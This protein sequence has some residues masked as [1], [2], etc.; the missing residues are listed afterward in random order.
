MSNVAGK[1]NQLSEKG[2]K[3]KTKS[4][5]KKET[6]DGSEQ[7]GA[8]QKAYKYTIR[9]KGPKSYYHPKLKRDFFR[10]RPVYTNNDEMAEECKLS[11]YFV[12]TGN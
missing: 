4:K 8:D 9:L 6:V 10:E 3:E 12:V 11:S 2:E 7:V 1:L 5:T